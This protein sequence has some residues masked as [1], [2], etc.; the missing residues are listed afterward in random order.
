MKDKKKHPIHYTVFHPNILIG[1]NTELKLA[2]QR[3]YM[4]VLNFNHLAE[5]DRLDYEIP[6]E[7]IT[8]ST[9]RKVI[10]KKAHQEF[11]RIAEVLQKRVFR[12]DKEFM[13]MHFNEKY[14]VTFNPFPVIKYKEKHFQ[15]RLNE[16]LKAILVK[17]ETG[18]TKGDIEL[19]RTFR[20]EYSFLMYWLIREQQWKQRGGLLDFSV[21]DLKKALG[22]ENQ[23]EGR[24]NNFKARVLDVVHEEFKGTWV[25][26]EYEILRGGKGGK[27]I[28]GI[29]FHFKNDSQQE[30]ILIPVSH[31]EW[32]NDLRRYGVQER[33]V[34]RI[35]DWVNLA[36]PLK[37]DYIWDVFYVETCITIAQEHYRGKK[38]QPKSRPIQS[39]ANY[40]YAALVNGWWL[41]EIEFRRSESQRKSLAL[42]VQAP[43]RQAAQQTSDFAP[44][45]TSLSGQVLERQAEIP[46][47]AA[48]PKF[49]MPYAD[50]QATYQ[51][52][53]EA[54]GEAVSEADFASRLGYVIVGDVVE[55]R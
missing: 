15:V 5:P 22:C 32:E 44:K 12:L 18:F 31:Y 51:A 4:E 36:A 19:L 54:T 27:A 40:I 35:R 2:E 29:R 42:L 38:Q 9:D 28:Q 46:F 49:T 34:I 16:Y 45:A 30:R 24:F 23:Y 41:P 1:V 20:S 37:D 3:L 10:Q 48:K 7:F 8:Q 43:I 39:M 21:E 53:C 50:F 11:T 47:A 13:Q 25:E 33:D 14:A 6:Y 52:Y 55:K 26:F 17:L